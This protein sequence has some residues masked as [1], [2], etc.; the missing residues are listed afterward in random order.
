MSL[1]GLPLA[2]GSQGDAVRD[3]QQRLAR[4]DFV[5][6][7]QEFGSYQQGTEA[8]VQAF[9]GE[10]GLRV[11]GICGRQTWSSLVEAGFTLGDRLLYLRQPMLRGDDVAALQRHLG[12]LGFDAGRVD[13]IFGPRTE[14]ALSEFQRNAALV[15]D[16]VSGPATLQILERLGGRVAGRQPVAVVREMERLR[17]SP[18]TLAGTHVVL[19]DGGGM[20]A[21]ISAIARVLGA[22]GARVTVLN[23]P[24]QSEQAQEANATGA[25]VFV[26]LVLDGASDGCTSAYYAGHRFESPAGQRLAELVQATIPP[27]LGIADR[28]TH[29]MAVPVLRETRMPAVLCELGPPTAV[30]AESATLA[31]S[32]THL[33]D[34]WVAAPCDEP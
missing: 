10:R 4:L 19:G 24:D 34:I 32:F 26:G 7:D 18:R 22:A 8:S 23:H 20:H 1:D 15:V 9:Q 16:G 14:A 5:V 13:A 33:M 27:A 25:Q 31:Q 12:A 29:G 30:V 3:L 6:S 28:G 11:D 17:Q 2:V 21:P